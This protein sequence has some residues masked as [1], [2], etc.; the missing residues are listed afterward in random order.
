MMAGAMA[1]FISVVAIGLWQLRDILWLPTERFDGKAL[2]AQ[3]VPLVLGVGATQFLFTSDT[4][5]AKSHFTQAEMACYG[6]AG[7]LS[8]ALLWLV[9]PLAAVMFPKI[10]HSTAKSEKTNLLGLVMIGTAILAI[11]GGVG[12]C[13]LGRWVVKI[14]S[15]QSYVETTNALLPWYAGAMVPLALA[16]VLVN[17]LLARSC[18]RVVAPIV[19]LAAIYGPTLVFFLNR[20]PGRLQLPLQILAVFNLLLLLVCAFFARRLKI[21]AEKL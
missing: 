6:L 16:N 18:F 17:D 11:C 19:V 8:R 3:V 5:F 7:T 14:V 9:M 20:F 13:V 2:L 1:G 15:Q 10:V 4:M 21:A 12:L